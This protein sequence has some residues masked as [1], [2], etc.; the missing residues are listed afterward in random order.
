MKNGEPLIGE[1]VYAT[2]ESH[3]PQDA[4]GIFDEV[5][6]T[7]SDGD[8]LIE[9]EITA[10]GRWYVRFI[11]LERSGEPEY[12]YSGLLVMLGAEEER[13]VYESKWATLTFEVR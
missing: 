9:F 1:H 13:V 6:K 3:Y 2:H 7:R 10:A 12:W 4:D 8:G 11:T 5:V